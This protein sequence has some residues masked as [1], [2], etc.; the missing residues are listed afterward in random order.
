MKRL[1]TYA[2]VLLMSFSLSHQRAVEYRLDYVL[3]LVRAFLEVIT[4]TV[5][6][7]VF[8]S[9]IDHING[10]SRYEALMVYGFFQFVS[11]LVYTFVGYGIND[12]PQNIISGRLDQYIVRPIDAQ[13][14]VSI[15]MAFITN[16]YRS[17]FGLALI[18]YTIRMLELS[19]S[20][21]SIALTIIATI[22][23]CMVYYALTFAASTL[24]FWTFADEIPE[25]M[26]SITAISRFPV[27]F[28]QR[29]KTIFYLLPIAFIATVPASALLA[30][31][32]LPAAISPFVAL[33]VY[34]ISR[35]LWF[36]GLKSYQSASS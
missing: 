3:R 7:L 2:K 14:Y 11:S 17:L 1:H 10:W 35:K 24:A 28:F 13:F 31:N 6:I 15:R 4:V 19:P 33:I 36:L 20:L 5:V 26:S 22:A 30:K 23:A 34:F 16:I 27:Q 25:I 29:L 9:N 8:Y 12:L 18:L 32:H 21:V